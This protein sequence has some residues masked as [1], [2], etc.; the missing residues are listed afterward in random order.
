MPFFLSRNCVAVVDVAAKSRREGVQYVRFEERDGLHEPSGKGFAPERTI[1]GNLGGGGGGLGRC[2][3]LRHVTV[4]VDI[5]DFV[6][7]RLISSLMC[8]WSSTFGV[9][10][11][12]IVG[13]V[14]VFDGAN[15]VRR[16]PG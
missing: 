13:R 8:C 16:L 9:G 3:Q 14:T 10:W 6:P 1:E 15:F 12:K 2:D 4:D 5:P 7:W 11:G